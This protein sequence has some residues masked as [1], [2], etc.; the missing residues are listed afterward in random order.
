MLSTTRV[1]RAGLIVAAAWILS[2]DDARADGWYM[3]INLGAGVADDPPGSNGFTT[4]FA[5]G[6]AGGLGGG[7]SF[8]AFR[9]E[10]EYHGQTFWV[11]D[12]TAGGVPRDPTADVDGTLET[13]AFMANGYIDFDIGGGWRPYAGVGAG[14]A[15]VTADY[16]FTDVCAVICG[17]DVVLVEDEDLVSA[18]QAR[19]GVAYEVSDIAEFY[20]G[21][22]YFMTGDPTFR[23]EVGTAFKQDGQRASIAE[24][25]ARIQF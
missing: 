14:V 17:V 12:Q 6:V 21:Y 18:F 25:G 10:G 1:C 7:Y 8:G 23:D 22:R 13:D 20:V 4:E 5:P 15:I 9:V 2:T 24:F 3:A 16:R 11:W 19:V